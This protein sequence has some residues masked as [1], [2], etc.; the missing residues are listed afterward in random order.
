MDGLLGNELDQS[1]LNYI[2]LKRIEYQ[3]I[4]QNQEVLRGNH[5]DILVAIGN[6][7]Q[8]LKERNF[9]SL[10]RFLKQIFMQENYKNGENKSRNQ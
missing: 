1:K 2:V 7:K 3:K 9:E 6:N 10:K 8:L 4:K 5:V